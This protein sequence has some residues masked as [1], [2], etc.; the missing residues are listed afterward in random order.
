MDKTKIFLSCGQDSDE[1]REI[2]SKIR[3]LLP[4]Y[5]V[6]VAVE[7]QSLR[8]VVEII[9]KELSESEYFLFIDFKR[10]K[11]TIQDKKTGKEKE[12]YRGSLFSH[13]E[14]A[15]ATYLQLECINFQEEE[16]HREGVLNYLLG[17][18]TMF[19]RNELIEKVI[20]RIEKECKPGWKNEL[21]FG[22]IEPVQVQ[23]ILGEPGVTGVYYH[24]FIDNEH[25]SKTAENCYVYL[26]KAVDLDSGNEIPLK[27][28]EHRW[29]GYGF[30]N[31]T[32][33]PRQERPFDAFVIKNNHEKNRLVFSTF[34]TSTEFMLNEVAQKTKLELTYIIYSDD[35]KP[36]E[37][38][39]TLKTTDE[40]KTVSFQPK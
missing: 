21:S 23:Y 30:P 38:I 19:K 5:D 29:S 15:L 35:F 36:I 1:E 33:L 9:F 14:L 24:I 40:W 25:K 8:G 3:K 18:P 32:I 31:A 27:T 16:V 28:I 17:N 2:V 6:Y 4:K 34:S 26:K 12:T 39:Y 37:K 13:Q 11:I 20:S 22:K 10:E 7:N